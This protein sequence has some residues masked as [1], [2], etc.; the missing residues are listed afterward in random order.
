[1]NRLIWH[2]VSAFVILTLYGGQVCPFIESLTLFQWGVSVFFVLAISFGCQW[3]YLMNRSLDLDA[4]IGIGRSYFH[5]LFIFMGS[6]VLLGIYNTLM[7]EFPITSSLKLKFGWLMVGMFISLDLMLNRRLNIMKYLFKEGRQL[8]IHQSY[9]S[10]TSKFLWVAISVTVTVLGVIFLVI[11]K[12]LDW[13]MHAEYG[14]MEVSISILKEF[15]FIFGV[16]TGYIVLVMSSYSKNMRHYLDCQNNA[17]DDVVDGNLNAVVPVSSQDEFGWMAQQ[18]NKMIVSL[19]AQTESLQ[20]T[21]DASILSLA[22]L[23]ETRDNETGGHIMRTQRYVKS[24]ALVLKDHP[25]YSVELTDR[26]IELIYKSAPLHDMGKVGIPDH[27]LLKPGRLTEDE[28]KVMKRHPNYGKKALQTATR[29]LGANSFMKYA[30]EIAFTHHEKWDGTGYPRKLKGDE[31]PLSG[32]LMAVADVYD[33]LISKR[34]YKGAMSHDEAKNIIVG[35]RGTHFDPDIVDAF[36]SAEE[37]FIQIAKEFSDKKYKLG[38]D[39]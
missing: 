29:A 1:M 12:D 15:I 23:A 17:L 7:H 26:N 27:I 33:A 19:K 14:P 5:T 31:I 9:V 38:T 16:I 2:Y 34:V 21:Q 36:L 8:E 24:L 4:E 11:V 32:R 37:E 13:I 6:A 35:D 30:E 39:K 22:S 18:T 20:L 28:F 25:S 3:L 10:F